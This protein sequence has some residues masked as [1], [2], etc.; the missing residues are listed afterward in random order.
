MP[1]DKGVN[2]V[3]ERARQA[4][5]QAGTW[6]DKGRDYLNNQKDQIRSAYE[7]GRQAYHDRRPTKGKRLPPS[8]NGYGPAEVNARRAGTNMDEEL[9]IFI[10]VT[11]AAVVLQ[12]LIL[13]GMFFAIRKLSTSLTAVAQEVKTQAMPV[14]EEGKQLQANIKRIVETSLPNWSWCS[15]M[16]RRSL[17]RLMRELDGSKAR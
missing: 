9:T 6:A 16:P 13:A 10:A 3:K 8:C 11:S 5:E 15:I 2:V 4:R 7:A 1:P 14:L 17:R 12:M